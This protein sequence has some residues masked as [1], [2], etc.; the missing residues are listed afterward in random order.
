MLRKILLPVD[1]TEVGKKAVETTGLLAKP[2][3]SK[4]WLITVVENPKIPFIEEFPEEEKKAILS[5]H[6]KLKEKAN[7]LLSQYTEQLKS[8]GLDVQYEVL[9]GDTV[10]NILD[11]SE[12]INPDLIIIPS[13]KKSDVE[14]KAVGSVSLRISSKSKYPVL[15]IKGKGFDKID[16]IVVSYDFLPSS[17]KALEFALSIAKTFNSKIIVVHADNDHG[18]T[19]IKSI[20]EKVRKHKAEKLQHLK[21][22]Y[23]NLEV[24]MKEG[25]PASVIV[26]I[27]T[28]ENA[29][30]IVVGKRQLPDEKRVFIGSTSYQ[31]LKESPVSVLIYRG[32]HE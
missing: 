3:G 10:E 28:K 11:F 20:V 7:Q 19:H 25:N 31:I 14:L 13:H 18:Y 4:V 6:D 9:E 22:L 29:D 27:A 15:V 16:K 1:L 17:Q 30:L 32:N 8:E 26:N 5:L 12:R 21:N 23:T 2:F 24:H